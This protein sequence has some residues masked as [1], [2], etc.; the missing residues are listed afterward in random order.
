[1]G[2]EMKQ[3]TC[4]RIDLIMSC[5]RSV[6]VIANGINCTLSG[7]WLTGSFHRSV[8]QEQEER[9]GQMREKSR[10]SD[11]PGEREPSFIFPQQG[12]HLRAEQVEQ[13][14]F[15]SALIGARMLTMALVLPM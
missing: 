2:V 11:R 10:E 14:V 15:Y 8:T 7:A 5:K 9:V 6:C 4:Q 13:W 1:M 3:I 12:Q